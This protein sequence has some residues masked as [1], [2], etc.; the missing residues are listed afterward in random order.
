MEFNLF[1]ETVEKT[2]YLELGTGVW[3]SSGG[4]QDDRQPRISFSISFSIV[5]QFC[6]HVPFLHQLRA[7]LVTS[8][9]FAH[10][11]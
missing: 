7:V 11:S 4:A 5:P 10:L 6:S 1:F 2:S 3:I 8:L 9:M